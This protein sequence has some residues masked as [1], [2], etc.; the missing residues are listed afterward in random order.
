ML[1]LKFR[2]IRPLGGFLGGLVYEAVK[3]D[4]DLWREV[5]LIISVP[6]HKD[7]QRERGFNQ[8]ER[9]GREI[10]RQAGIPFG[11]GVLV[12]IRSTPP[13]TS[14]EYGARVENV[15]GAYALGRKVSVEGKTLLL[16]DDV[17][18]TGSTLGECARVLRRAGAA[19]VRAITVAQA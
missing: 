19:D 6:L 18:T 17:F 10:A 4:E 1:L 14:L 11:R 5:D 16:V 2:K 9:I 7:R 15:R 13:Q 12:K 3:K 8:A